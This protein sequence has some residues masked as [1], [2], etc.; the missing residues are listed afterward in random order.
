MK[1]VKEIGFDIIVKAFDTNKNPEYING[2]IETIYTISDHEEVTPSEPIAEEVPKEE[3]PAEPVKEESKK[4]AAKKKT[5]K[6]GKA[7]MPKKNIDMGKVGALRKAGWSW[8]KIGDEFSVSATTVMNHW[9]EY[10]NSIK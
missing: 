2:I 8:A 4:P 10:Q 9:E 5:S 3:E 7:G 1:N 6:G